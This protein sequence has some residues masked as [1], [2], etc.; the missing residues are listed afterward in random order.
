MVLL[1][2]YG[3]GEVGYMYSAV[4]CGLRDMKLF[5]T[6]VP[7]RRG[8]GGAGG[9]TWVPGVIS[10]PVVFWWGGHPVCPLIFPPAVCVGPLFA[11]SCFFSLVA[12]SLVLIFF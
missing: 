2:V 7:W 3:S 8:G 11:L 12:L 6:P 10:R 5:E 1:L 4:S 9:S